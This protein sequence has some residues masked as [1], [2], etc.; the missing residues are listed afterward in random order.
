L[1]GEI[2]MADMKMKRNGLGGYLLTLTPG[3]LKKW[4]HLTREVN[5]DGLIP[6]KKWDAVEYKLAI[7]KDEYK[8]VVTTHQDAKQYTVQM[9]SLTDEASTLSRTYRTW[10]CQDNIMRMMLELHN[11]KLA[12]DKAKKKRTTKKQA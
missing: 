11:A 7:K 4:E 5:T 2:K 9:T 10:E 8:V 3:Q 1:K 12:G 6:G